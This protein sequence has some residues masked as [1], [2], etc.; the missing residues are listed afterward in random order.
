MRRTHV[1]SIKQVKA[2]FTICIKMATDLLQDTSKND[3][4]GISGK[5]IYNVECSAMK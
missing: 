4:I 3:T 2:I 1:S 5:K